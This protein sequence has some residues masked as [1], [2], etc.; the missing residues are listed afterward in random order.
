MLSEMSG[1]VI[2][3]MHVLKNYNSVG[4]IPKYLALDGFDASL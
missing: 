2:S 4:L 3:I 1:G